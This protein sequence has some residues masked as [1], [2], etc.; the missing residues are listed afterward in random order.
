[1][2]KKLCKNAKPTDDIE[3]NL[4]KHMNAKSTHASNLLTQYT[5]QNR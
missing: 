4:H 2:L 3:K 5:H 1:M